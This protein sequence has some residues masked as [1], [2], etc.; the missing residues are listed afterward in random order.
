[1]E[2]LIGTAIAVVLAV[3]AVLTWRRGHPRVKVEL[4]RGDRVLLG[5]ATAAGISTVG[6]PTVT[7]VVTNLAHTT[8]VTVKSVEIEAREKHRKP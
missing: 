1:V 3:V 7:V 4:E 6:W 5:V 8:T 2:W